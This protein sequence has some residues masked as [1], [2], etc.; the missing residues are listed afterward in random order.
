MPASARLRTFRWS[1]SLCC[2]RPRIR[3]GQRYPQ[4]RERTSSRGWAPLGQ[5]AEHLEAERLAVILVVE[6]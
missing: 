3:E 4:C 6:R 5:R 1:G 2:R